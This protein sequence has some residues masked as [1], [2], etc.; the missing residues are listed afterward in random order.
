MCNGN[1]VIHHLALHLYSHSHL[2]CMAYYLLQ[3]NMSVKQNYIMVYK[4]KKVAYYDCALLLYR[5]FLS[6]YLKT[7]TST[8]SIYLSI[9]F[10]FIINTYSIAWNIK[11][12][13]VKCSTILMWEFYF[14]WNLS[15]DILRVLYKC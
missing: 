12:R 10:S 5:F 11:F 2:H 1:G 14:V 15:A 13:D 6:T 4:K 9:S 3:Q 7:F 8:L